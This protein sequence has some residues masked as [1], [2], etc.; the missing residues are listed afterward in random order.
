MARWVLVVSER[1]VREAQLGVLR[2]AALEAQLGVPWP[3]RCW[4][5]WE[6]QQ[7]KPGGGVPWLGV[8]LARWVLVLLGR[9][10]GEAWHV[11]AAGT[12]L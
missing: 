10:A 5:S 7:V 4:W 3:E 12:S 8:P 2:R 9:A 11:P 1:V 6:G